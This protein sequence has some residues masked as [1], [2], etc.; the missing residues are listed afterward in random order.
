MRIQFYR[1]FKHT[2]YRFI[3]Q[4]GSCIPD[5]EADYDWLLNSICTVGGKVCLKVITSQVH[6][7][8]AD[9]GYVQLKLTW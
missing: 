5:Y 2:L 4:F 3:I 9:R 1:S 6:L 8:Q 7:R